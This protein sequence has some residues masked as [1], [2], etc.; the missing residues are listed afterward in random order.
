MKTSSEVQEPERIKRKLASLAPSPLLASQPWMTPEEGAALAASIRKHGILADLLITDGDEIIDGRNRWRQAPT[1][2]VTEAWCRVVD[3]AE[4]AHLVLT[5]IMERRHYSKSARAYLAL[6]LL[7][8]A[9][10]EAVARRMATLKQGDNLPKTDS[11]GFRGQKGSEELAQQLGLSLD[12]LQLARHT[13]KLF[14]D[15]DKLIERWLHA[16]THEREL[17]ETFNGTGAA[18]WT[19]F[20][21]SRLADMGEDPAD[22]ST[23]AIFPENYREVFEGHLFSGTMGLGQINKALGSILA[24]KGKTRSDLAAED[25]G[26]GL[27]LTLQRKLTS[28]NRTMWKHWSDLPVAGRSEVIRDF[29]AGLKD[30]PHDVQVAAFARLKEELKK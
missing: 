6:P 9:V 11:I 30:W 14:A 27:H 24:T 29:Q 10:A 2:G 22:P 5:M 17:W 12:L 18:T 25:A 13:A 8:K 15:S 7:E 28:F 21:A 19:Q 4:A 3:D 16:N 23:A 20:R 1:V 26:A